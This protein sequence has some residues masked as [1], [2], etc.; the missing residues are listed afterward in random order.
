M[1]RSMIWAAAAFALAAAGGAAW[2]LWPSHAPHREEASVSNTGRILYYQD[3]SGAPDYSPTPKKDA[4][5]RDYVAVRAPA[6]A[7]P[8]KDKTVLYYRNPMGLADT[9]PTPKKDSMGMDYI[10]VYADEGADQ[11][12]TV[13]ISLDRVQRLGV[14]TSPVTRQAMNETV[15]LTGTVMADERKLG[16][17]ALKFPANIVK[18]HVAA[19]GEKVRAGQALFEI[20]SPFLLQ[21][22]T[23]L[24][25]A[26]KAQAVSQ[27]LGDVYARTNERS[28][29]S[30][31][32]RLENYEVPKREIERL[33]RTREAKGQV[34]WPAPQDGVVIEKPIVAGMQAQAGETLY[35]LADLSNVWVIAEAPE[36]LLAIARPGAT[37]RVAL[38]AYPGKTF[39]GKV[40]FVYPE[41]SMTTRTAKVRIELGNAEGLLLPGMFASVE[42]A[43]PPGDAVLAVPD[44]ALIDSGRRQVVLVARGEGRFE[45]R[46]VAAG[47]RANGMVE[48]ASGL[49]GNETVVTSAT[50]LIDAE[51]NL[52]AAL[53]SFTAE[54][55]P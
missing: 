37:A 10:P 46:A 8:A 3:P 52:R 51:S 47:R 33:I 31:R 50:F 12:G 14:R 11:P 18:L 32:A 6:E 2:W 7:Q 38:N 13:K 19:A 43:S 23:T 48:I 16:V 34:V 5:G 41:V 24:A 40:T 21:Q 53:Q 30:A 4:Q 26:L 22:E 15:Q 45:P 25:L 1:R 42:V 9:S 27:E 44:S 28:A 35:R 20:N 54:Q 39:E 36:S 17:V 49:D 29:T 55:K